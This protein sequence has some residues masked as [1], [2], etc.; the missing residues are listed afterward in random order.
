MALNIIFLG[1]DAPGVRDKEMILEIMSGYCFVDRD[2][3]HAKV[4]EGMS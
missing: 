4:M 1:I 3:S 2:T